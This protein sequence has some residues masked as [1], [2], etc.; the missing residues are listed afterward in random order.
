MLKCGG[1]EKDQQANLYYWRLEKWE[2]LEWC[3][4]V[5]VE[6]MILVEESRTEDHLKQKDTPN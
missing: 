2:W 1:Y 5:G 6:R 3:F 4:Q